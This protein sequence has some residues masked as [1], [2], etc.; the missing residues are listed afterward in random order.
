MDAN[1]HWDQTCSI[2]RVWAYFL[3][4]SRS[5]VSSGLRAK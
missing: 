3:P 2:G 5:E 1:A 4:S